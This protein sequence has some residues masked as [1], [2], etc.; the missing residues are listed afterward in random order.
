MPSAIVNVPPGSAFAA[1]GDPLSSFSQVS[2][3]YSSS[4]VLVVT[5]PEPTEGTE[6]TAPSK[7]T[8]PSDRRAGRERGAMARKN[9]RRGAAALRSLGFVSFGIDATLLYALAPT[10]AYSPGPKGPVHKR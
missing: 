6:P 9:S 5:A 8:E 4:D 2:Q 7:P 1:M 3:T 10:D